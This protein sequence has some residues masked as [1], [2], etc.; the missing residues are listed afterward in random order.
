MYE[1]LRRRGVRFEFFYRVDA[2]HLSDDKCR[3]AAI[4]I[5]RQVDL[6]HPGSGYK[7]LKTIRGLPCWPAGPDVRQLRD[8][9]ADVAPEEFESFWSRRPDAGRVTL[10]DGQDFDVVVLGISIGA[11]PYLCQQLIEH[12][13]RWAVM[14][15]QVTSIQT[16]TFQLWL[17]AS[18]EELGVEWQ[19]A[20]V[21]GY[22]EP[23]DTYAD[24]QQLIERESWGTHV[25][26]IAYFC[27]SMSTPKGRLDRNDRDFPEREKQK[28]YDNARR[29]LADDV[30]PLWPRSVHRYPTEFRWDLLAGGGARTGPDR[31]KTQFWR[32]NID[33][34]ERYVLSIPGTARFRLHPGDSGF[35]NL[36]LAGDWT[37]CGLNAG[38][39]EAAVTSGM[40]AANAIC[41]I[42]AL[43][44]IVGHDHP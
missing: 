30:T 1:A 15:D 11:L 19:Q 8:V 13:A 10:R 31:L 22:L 34:S 33:P 14:V 21:G 4:D 2:L 3:I 39:V 42:P 28:V 26:S 16:Q 37:E 17:T 25:K 35:D 44:D 38:C 27:N 29:F 24:M 6:L 41:G 36:F 40:L 5:G 18:M 7:P 12:D 20:T 9:R 32:A 43:E 23:F